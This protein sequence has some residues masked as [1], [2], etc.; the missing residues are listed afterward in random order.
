MVQN[1]FKFQNFN[2]GIVTL[3]SCADRVNPKSMNDLDYVC[4][5][6]YGDSTITDLDR[7]I[8]EGHE[9]SETIKIKVPD[10]QMVKAGLYA[11]VQ[12]FRTGKK[13]LFNIYSV[14][15][16]QSARCVFLFIQEVRASFVK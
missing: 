11:I 7:S 9:I 1:K 5:L 6:Q 8:T 4:D 16:N 3:Y 12:D 14:S 10:C 15:P 2:A 13:N